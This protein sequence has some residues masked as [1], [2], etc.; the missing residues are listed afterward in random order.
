[1]KEREIVDFIIDDI[2]GRKGIGNEWYLIDDYIKDEIR[3]EWIE[4]TQEILHLED[5]KKSD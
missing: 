4:A 1:M 5:Q 3:Q 2:S